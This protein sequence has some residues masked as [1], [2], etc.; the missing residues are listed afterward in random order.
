MKQAKKMDA[1]DALN[2]LGKDLADGLMKEYQYN[3]YDIEVIGSFCREVSLTLLELID[4]MVDDADRKTD[5]KL[6]VSIYTAVYG[7]LAGTADEAVK[8]TREVVK[9]MKEKE[10][11]QKKTEISFTGK[12]L[13][14]K[15]GDALLKALKEAGI[16]T[17]EDL[18]A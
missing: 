3:D 6:M 18:E 16:V 9:E 4:E 5:M 17:D 11:T 2:D 8:K 15:Q 14:K 12:K 1:L 13:T 7:V 10:K